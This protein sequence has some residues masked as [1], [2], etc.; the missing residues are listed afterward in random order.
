M[1]S[2]MI[3]QL[4]P[5]SRNLFTRRLLMPNVFIKRNFL[6]SRRGYDPFADIQRSFDSFFREMERSFFPTMN[7]LR[8]PLSRALPMETIEDGQRIEKGEV[9]IDA[10]CE[11]TDGSSKQFK[12]INYSYSL[13]DDV[14]LDRVRSLL[15]TDGRLVIEAP[16]P[17]LEAPKENR[18]IPIKRE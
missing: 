14:D 5:I 4:V 13:P 11:I 18:E 9:K 12:Q 10:K 6:P 1:S 3:R 16:L 7:Q 17:A 8:T 15:K 2:Q